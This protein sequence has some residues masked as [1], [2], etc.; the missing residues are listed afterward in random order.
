MGRVC[1]PTT[2]ATVATPTPSRPNREI[3]V[4][5]QIE[6]AE[7]F[8]ALDDILAIEGLDSI[9][10][11]PWDLSASLGLLGDVEHPTVIEAVDSIIART[12]AAGLFVGAG[13]APDARFALGM[14]K[15]GV[16]WLQVGDDCGYMILAMDQ[17]TAEVR[18]Q[19]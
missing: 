12:R 11:G 15:R 13:M 4:A 2:G 5:V 7:A 17:I 8:A 1:P 10:L 19:L 6:N 3:F 16:Q 14:A 9:A 18:S